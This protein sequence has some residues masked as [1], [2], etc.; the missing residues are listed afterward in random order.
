MNKIVFIVSICVILGTFVVA[1]LAVTTP[2]A[3]LIF[4]LRDKWREWRRKA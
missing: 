1:V 2:G 4:W 3:R